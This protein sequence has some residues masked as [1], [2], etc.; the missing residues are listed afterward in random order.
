MDCWINQYIN[1]SIYRPL[2]GSSSV[3]L[4]AEL[5]SARKGLINIENEDKKCFFW[6][7]VR[8][9]NLVKICPE[10]ITKEDKNLANDLDYDGIVFPVQ[11]KKF[12]NIE[13]KQHLH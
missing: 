5:R 10:K 6:C 1:I 4:P 2:L 7:H 11:E 9:I 13:K 3:K 12:S 8:H